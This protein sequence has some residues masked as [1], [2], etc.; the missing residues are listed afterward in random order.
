MALDQYANHVSAEDAPTDEDMT[1]Y[2]QLEREAAMARWPVPF[3]WHDLD[4]WP[5]QDDPPF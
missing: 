1:A 4:Y 3:E 5:L 2:E